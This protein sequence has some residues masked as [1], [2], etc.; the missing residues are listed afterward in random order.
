MKVKNH[1]GTSRAGSPATHNPLPTTNEDANNTTSHAANP[2]HTQTSHSHF[3]SPATSTQI[4]TRSAV[5]AAQQQKLNEPP[6]ST[7]NSAKQPAHTHTLGKIV[8]PIP[9]RP[10]SSSSSSSSTHSSKLSAKF[11]HGNLFHLDA[12]DG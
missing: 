9:V 4:W 8:K 6:A 12:R 7:R 5:R 11:L 3:L 10:M 2:S 1:P